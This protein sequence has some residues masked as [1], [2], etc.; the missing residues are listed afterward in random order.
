MNKNSKYD[1]TFPQQIQMMNALDKIGQIKQ[2]KLQ[3]ADFETMNIVVIMNTIS[4]KR[5]ENKDFEPAFED[6]MGSINFCRLA[7][8]FLVRK[9]NFV[10]GELTLQWVETAEEKVI[11]QNMTQNEVN[12]LKRHQKIECIKSI[13]NRLNVG[14]HDAKVMMDIAYEHMLING[15]I[16]QQ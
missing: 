1:T 3:T 2:L 7:D 8:N 15:I 10:T 9:A 4:S 13:R 6:V 12:L 5:K 11:F 14:L 16:Q